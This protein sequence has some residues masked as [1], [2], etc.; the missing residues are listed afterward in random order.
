MNQSQAHHEPTRG[1]VIRQS[2]NDGQ[3]ATVPTREQIA[4]RAHEI[5][6]K[7]GSAEGHCERNWAQAEQELKQELLNQKQD[8]EQVMLNEGGTSSTAREQAAE[9]TTGSRPAIVSSMKAAPP[10]PPQ[11]NG[12]GNRQAED[13]TP[14]TTDPGVNNEHRH[15]HAHG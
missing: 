10:A 2:R 15:H 1:P 12:A 9:A 14:T 11:F 6:V 4:K 3:A 5:Y 13:A 7:G 8:A